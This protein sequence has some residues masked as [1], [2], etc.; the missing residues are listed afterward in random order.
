MLYECP[1]DG[2]EAKIKVFDAVTGERVDR[3]PYEEIR[4]ASLYA[5]ELGNYILQNDLALREAY[6]AAAQNG[7][8]N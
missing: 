4:K 3:A 7:Q 8:G 1:F 5:Y 2:I 6:N